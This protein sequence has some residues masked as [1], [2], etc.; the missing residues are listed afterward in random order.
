M[1]RRVSLEGS[2]GMGIALLVPLIDPANPYLRGVSLLFGGLFLADASRK[3]PW[4]VI[5]RTE[6]SIITGIRSFEVES[7]WRSRGLACLTIVLVA[8]YG[9]LTWPRYEQHTNT[10][11]T[12]LPETITTPG[13]GTGD[14]GVVPISK[15]VV[16][17]VTPVVKV[18]PKKT[19]KTGEKE[20]PAPKPKPDP[21]SYPIVTLSGSVV[22]YDA[23]N[24]KIT[25]AVTIANTTQTEANA[26]I[27][28]YGV[29]FSNGAATTAPLNMVERDIG[30]P[31]PPNTSTLTTEYMFIPEAKPGYEDG[32]NYIM[33]YVTVS[34]P[35]RGG[36]TTYQFQ[37]R[38]R[39]KTSN[40]D[41]QSSG[42]D[43]PK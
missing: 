17:A 12:L 5:E 38:T 24:R 11:V 10:A 15:P 16:P 29:G 31:P 33:L 1:E 18:A 35:D 2:L 21:V 40:L 34:Y 9:I 25:V 30:L 37:G 19:P 7:P 41:E 13:G 36:T 28:I 14:K 27:Q 42:W 4:A 26:H 3:T 8:V 6:S 22:T 20:K 43:G 32:T 39:P 23:D